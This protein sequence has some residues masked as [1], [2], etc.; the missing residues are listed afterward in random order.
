MSAPCPAPSSTYVPARGDKLADLLDVMEHLLA[1][2]GC[3]WD[4]EQTLSSLKNYLIEE[5]FEVLDAIDESDAASHCE[6]L[7]DVLFQIVFQ[8]ALRAREGA[9]N[10]DDVC[11]NIAEKMR[12]RHPHVFGDRKVKDAAEVVQNWGAIKAEERKTAGKVRRTLDGIPKSMPAL[13]RGQLIADR[14]AATG[15][16]WPDIAGVRAKIDEELAELDAEV[17]AGIETASRDRI[18]S[19]FG[20]VLFTL[21]RL[22]GKL[23]IDAEQALRRANTRFVGRFEAMEDRITASGQ[24]I[25]QLTLPQMNQHWESVKRSQAE[26]KR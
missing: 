18:E 1:E 17:A 26:D 12:R 24:Q 9:F 3:P 16:D 11:Q 13:K 25:S 19:E 23:G 4:R 14:A 7:G 20:D 6:E 21:T 5:S 8:S 10:I 2:D 15:F 22:A